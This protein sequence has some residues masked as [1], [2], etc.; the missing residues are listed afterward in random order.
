MKRLALQFSS[1]NECK[2]ILSYAI[3]LYFICFS[4]DVV[5]RM[6][7]NMDIGKQLKLIYPIKSDVLITVKNKGIPCKIL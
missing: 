2:S 4:L 5:I 6:R 7:R 1:W 3:K